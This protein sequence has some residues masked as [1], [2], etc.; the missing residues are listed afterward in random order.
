MAKPSLWN[1][2]QHALSPR[3][4]RQMKRRKN[5]LDSRFLIPLLSSVA[6]FAGSLDA[7]FNKY[8]SEQR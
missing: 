3:S 8:R 2:T 5:R 6:R 7:P 4:G 1:L